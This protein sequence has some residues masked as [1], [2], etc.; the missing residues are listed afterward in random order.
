LRAQE[1]KEKEREAEWDSWFNQERP[2]VA[3]AKTWKEKRIEKGGS[4]TG[5]DDG[6]EPTRGNQK[7]DINMVFHLSTEFGCLKQTTRLE[8][9]TA[10]AVFEKPETLRRHMKPLYI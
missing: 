4:E 5:S 3:S 8:L 6:H 1:I 9:G 2:M 10:R 7:V